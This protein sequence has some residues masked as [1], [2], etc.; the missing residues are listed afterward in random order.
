MKN[1]SPEMSQ[2]KCHL[3]QEQK[4]GRLVIHFVK[5][6]PRK[7]KVTDAAIE[8]V[9]TLLRS[10]FDEVL[11]MNRPLSS[12]YSMLKRKASGKD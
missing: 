12:I 10:Y 11:L 3:S 4:M 5:H 9:K 2:C 7:N 8:A 1:R 6:S